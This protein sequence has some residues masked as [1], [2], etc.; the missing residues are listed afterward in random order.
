M[1][2]QIDNIKRDTEK[3]KR[4]LRSCAH[5]I[6]SQEKISSIIQDVYATMTQEI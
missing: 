2:A 1:T 6:A 5:S 4:I 3:T